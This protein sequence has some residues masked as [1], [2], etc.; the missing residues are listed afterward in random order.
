[1]SIEVIVLEKCL[2]TQW[3]NAIEAWGSLRSFEANKRS[4]K[5][6]DWQTEKQSP[7]SHLDLSMRA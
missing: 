3:R 4:D 2:G 5:L 1:M 7:E 6:T